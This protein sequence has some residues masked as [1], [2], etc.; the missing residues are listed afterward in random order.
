MRGKNEEGKE[1]GIKE[2]KR[3]E[4]GRDRRSVKRGE[5]PSGM[6]RRAE[7]DWKKRREDGS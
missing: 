1:E 2:R 5:M 4:L 6:R 3:G 7:N